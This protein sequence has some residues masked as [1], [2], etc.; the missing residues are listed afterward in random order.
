MKT[1][2]PRS[3]RGTR[4][5]TSDGS[6]AS[7]S[8][9][10]C[11]TSALVSSNVDARENRPNPKRNSTAV[12]DRRRRPGIEI[13]DDLCRLERVVDRPQERVQLDRAEIRDPRERRGLF[14]EA[15]AQRRALLPLDLE[16]GNPRWPAAAL[17]L[18]P[19]RPVH[20]LGEPRE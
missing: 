5:M 11:R 4:A 13:E 12:D 18:I 3:A 7:S 8:S 6:A 9:A 19:A 10:T 17:R 1:R 15:V 14:D 16:R 2:P 20:A